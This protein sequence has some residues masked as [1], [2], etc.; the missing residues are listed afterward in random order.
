MKQL[1]PYD[2]CAAPQDVLLLR[3]SLSGDFTYPGRPILDALAAG[4]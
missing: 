2:V 3:L 1:Q 4:R